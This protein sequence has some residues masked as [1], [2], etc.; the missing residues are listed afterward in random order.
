MTAP[1]HSSVFTYRASTVHSQP[2]WLRRRAYSSYLFLLLLN[3]RDACMPKAQDSTVSRKCSFPWH[4]AK[5]FAFVLPPR[6]A[7]REDKGHQTKGL[8][9]HQEVNF[10]L[11]QSIFLVSSVHY[12]AQVINSDRTG[13]PAQEPNSHVPFCRY[14]SCLHHLRKMRAVVDL[15]GWRFHRH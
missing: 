7:E 9:F 12:V 14:S 10:L 4:T 15:S 13:P 1:C 11:Y 3:Q 6:G 2:E 8:R 5:V